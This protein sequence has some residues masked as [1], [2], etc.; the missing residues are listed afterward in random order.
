MLLGLGLIRRETLLDWHHGRRLT[1][2]QLLW[3]GQ[4]RRL[5]THETDVPQPPASPYEVAFHCMSSEKGFIFP[6][7]LAPKVAREL[8]GFS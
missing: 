4:E 1:S 3:A 8:L 7:G 5:N 6:P 2:T